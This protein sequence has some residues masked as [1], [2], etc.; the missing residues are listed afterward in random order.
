SAPCAEQYPFRSFMRQRISGASLPPRRRGTNRGKP[1]DGASTTRSLIREGAQSGHWYLDG[2]MADVTLE[3][4]HY[5]PLGL[6]TFA[7]RLTGCADV[8]TM[9]PSAYLTVGDEARQLMRDPTR[10][11]RTWRRYFERKANDRCA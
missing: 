11:F 5:P 2:T 6:T 1:T 8:C 3:Q 9:L 4:A 10:L 7:A